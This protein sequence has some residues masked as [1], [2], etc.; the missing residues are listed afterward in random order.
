MR[1]IS[2]TIN[3]LDHQDLSED[4][5]STISDSVSVNDEIKE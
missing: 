2:A 1:D 3:E 4:L 5:L